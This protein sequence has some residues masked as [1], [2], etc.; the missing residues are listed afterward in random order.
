MKYFAFVVL[1]P[2]AALGVALAGLRYMDYL[3]NPR[4]TFTSLEQIKESGLIERGWLPPF[5]PP[6]IVQIEESHD[7]D[8][9]RVWASFKYTIGDL[10]SVESAC[11]QIAENE[12]GKKYLCPPFD[13][14]TSTLTLRNDGTGYY[15]S[16]ENGI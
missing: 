16:Y 7:I 10:E 15:L 13:K 11:D 2:L 4:S 8:T 12:S 1:L 5:L 3:E 6:S 9:N 14:R